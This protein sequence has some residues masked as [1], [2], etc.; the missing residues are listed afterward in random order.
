MGLHDRILQFV[1]DDKNNLQIA[2][3]GE[4][5]GADEKEAVEGRYQRWRAG[6]VERHW[7]AAKATGVN[8]S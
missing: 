2:K 3:A 8:G 7:E 1:T 6:H 5:S 4:R